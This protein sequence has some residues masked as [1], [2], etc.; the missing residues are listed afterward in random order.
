MC[1]CVCDNRLHALF[2]LCTLSALADWGVLLTAAA[3]AAAQ[4]H[5]H[6]VLQWLLLVYFLAWIHQ[7]GKKVFAPEE[8]ERTTDR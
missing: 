5:T 4:T 8:E 6:S 1:V 7:Y 2:L 3:T